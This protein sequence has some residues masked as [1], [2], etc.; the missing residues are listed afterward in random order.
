MEKDFKV[1]TRPIRGTFYFVLA[2]PLLLFGLFVLFDSK[3][4]TQGLPIAL[5]CAVCGG[6]LAWRAW[7]NLTGAEDMR[8]IGKPAVAALVTLVVYG[9]ILTAVQRAHVSFVERHGWIL[10]SMGGLA[11]VSA[12]VLFLH[13]GGRGRAA[14]TRNRWES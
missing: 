1:A 4:V 10:W 9:R 14:S 11:L 8:K 2:A 3:S 13:M 7:A 5:W 12:V 6:L